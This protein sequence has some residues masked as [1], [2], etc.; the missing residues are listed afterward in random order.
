MKITFELS[1]G[2]LVC[3]YQ[4]EAENVALKTLGNHHNIYFDPIPIND[5]FDMIWTDKLGGWLLRYLLE[6]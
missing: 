5:K 4:D 3:P 2:K 1:K 6:S